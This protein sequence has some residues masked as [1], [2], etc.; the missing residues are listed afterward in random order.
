MS[1]D[2]GFSEIDVQFARFL[3]RVSGDA[4]PE[5]LAGAALASNARGRGNICLD[6]SSEIKMQ[7]GETGADLNTAFDPASLKAALARSP[8]VGRPGDYKPLILDGSRLYLYRYW[9]YEDTL[10]KELKA[11]SMHL[12]KPAGSSLRESIAR[13]FAK[14]S[15]GQ[16]QAAAIAAL[17]SFT[18]ITGGPG[19]GKT[20][21]VARTIALLNEQAGSGKMLRAALAAPTGKAAARLQESIRSEIEALDCDAGARSA[22]PVEASTVHRL[23]RWGPQGF[24]YNRSNRLDLDLV[25]LDEASMVDLA[26]L[27]RLVQALPPDCRLILLGDR[28]QL[29][30]V[31]AGAVLGDICGKAGF[32]SYSPEMR[33]FLSEAI[34][35]D[36]APK[37][38]PQ[39]SAGISDC[40]AYLQESFRFGPASGIGNLSRAV[41]AGDSERAIASCEGNAQAHWRD[42]PDLNRLAAALRGPVLECFAP[43]LKSPGPEE[44]LRNLNGFRILSAL[45]E[46]PFGVRALNETVKEVLRGEG[47]ISPSFSQ[48]GRSYKGCPIMIT[49]NNY[50]L[51]LYNGDVGIVW[52]DPLNKKQLRAFFGS[53]STEGTRSFPLFSLPEH[54]TVYAMTVHKSQGSEFNRVLLILPDRDTPLLTR[55]LVYTAVTRAREQVEIWGKREIFRAAL[56]RRIE[57]SSGLREALWGE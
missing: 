41:N 46:G 10:A 8:A 9:E 22:I 55:E 11:R 54:E 45:R 36:F 28:D 31:E 20:S 17:K 49:S 6:L 51:D 34:G 19:T 3:A 30:S 27:S 35:G 29:A 23:L 48:G 14:S 1:V 47:L 50:S 56:S 16:K 53:A 7:G 25:V 57:R 18:V 52:P 21:V 15:P 38:E 32:G 24:R 33:N 13:L 5:L 39:A 43:V 2:H 12:I 37:G 26:L 44:A 40:I 4:S 42:L